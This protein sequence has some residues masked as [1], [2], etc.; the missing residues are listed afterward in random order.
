MISKL[1]ECRGLVYLRVTCL[2]F[3]FQDEKNEMLHTNMWLN[4]VSVTCPD[5]HPS[6][7]REYLNQVNSIK[8]F[9]LNKVLF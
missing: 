6:L 1:D 5:F 3:V 2:C 9:A 7:F 8:Y 4:Y